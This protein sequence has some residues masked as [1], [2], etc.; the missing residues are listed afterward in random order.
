MDTPT[1]LSFEL[2]FEQSNRVIKPVA[3]AENEFLINEQECIELVENKSLFVTFSSIDKNAKFFFEGLDSLPE[4]SVEMQ[5]G[6]PYLPS[7][8][9]SIPIIKSDYYPLIPGKYL[10][11]VEANA[12]YYYAYVKIIPNQISVE[13]WSIMKQEVENHLSGLAKDLIKRK[14][15]ISPESTKDIPISQISKYLI[16]KQ[17]FNSVAPALVDLSSKANYKIKKIYS[18][19]PIER[20]KIF[21]EKSYIHRLR[22]PEKNTI[23]KSPVNT[24]NYNLP[25]NQWVKKITQ[26]LVSILIEFINTVTSSINIVEEEIESIAPYAKYQ[27]STRNVIN[28]K[29]KVIQYLK[30]LKEDAKKIRNTFLSIESSNWYSEVSAFENIPLP[31]VMNLDSRYRA[32]YQL[33]RN[34]KKDQ[35]E[36][37]LDPAYYLQWKRT[38]KLYEIWGFIQLIEVLEKQLGFQPVK[39]WIFSSEILAN[40]IIPILDGNTSIEF[41]RNSQI[42]KLVYDGVIPRIANDTHKYDNPI[43]AT[44]NNNMPDIRLDVF[45]DDT[46]SG[47]IIIDFKYRSKGSV[48]QSSLLNTSYKNTTMSQ[49]LTYATSCKSYFLYGGNIMVRH[50]NPVHEVWAVHPT[51]KEKNLQIDS[52]D[53][54][55]LKLVQMSPGHSRTHIEVLLE[56]KINDISKNMNDFIKQFI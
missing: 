42:I 52:Y 36:F 12:S 8:S 26:Y 31:H 46:Y 55:N 17:H 38:D 35:P 30:N 43:Y 24:F 6:V 1:E 37:K 34:L 53:D 50:I 47:T 33:Y 18:M 3:F 14:L 22:F 27:E 44:L 28:E 10:V 32:L 49:L 11:K 51:Q 19:L 9:Y 15:N 41:R 39:G 21:D 54:Y 56:R 25:E 16:I 13:Q 29:K 7:P 4:R 45:N 40:S 48:W 23:I 5:D 2:F 20:A